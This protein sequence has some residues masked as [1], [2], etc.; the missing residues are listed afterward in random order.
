MLLQGGSLPCGWA[1]VQGKEHS[2]HR[3]PL[4]GPPMHSSSH[5]C[6]LR[7]LRTRASVSGVAL[8]RCLTSHSSDCLLPPSFSKQQGHHL[9]AGGALTPGSPTQGSSDT[10]KKGPG[11]AL[12]GASCRDPSPALRPPSLLLRKSWAGESGVLGRE[13][14][15]DPR[16][17]LGAGEQT[18]GPGVPEYLW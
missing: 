4:L 3:P 12:T 16:G 13:E 17:K 10:G 5:S 1:E 9:P 8:G 6:K 15:G 7:P 2:A 18:L 11:S 14:G